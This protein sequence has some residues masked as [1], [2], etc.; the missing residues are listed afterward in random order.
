MIK[1]DEEINIFV[2]Y[3]EEFCMKVLIVK[4]GGAEKFCLIK[5]R[6]R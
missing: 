1:F 4:N 3:N 2:Q 6:V 5:R